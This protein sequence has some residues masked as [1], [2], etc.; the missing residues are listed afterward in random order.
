[1]NV[2]MY[3]NPE[4]LR[5]GAR[6]REFNQYEFTD[7]PRQQEYTEISN[8]NKRKPGVSQSVER[9]VVISPKQQSEESCV[10]SSQRQDAEEALPNTE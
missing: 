10:M 2:L 9:N 8:N 3:I 5:H 4:K 7:T 1:M 6:K